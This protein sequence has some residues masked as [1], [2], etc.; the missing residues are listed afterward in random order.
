MIMHKILIAALENIHIRLLK[1]E[2][3]NP[4]YN[5]MQ[6]MTKVAQAKLY[7]TLVKDKKLDKRSSDN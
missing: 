3:K 7:L 4:D 5:R 6:A 1:A 2:R